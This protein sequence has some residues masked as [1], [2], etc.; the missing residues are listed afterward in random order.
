M[1]SISA[2]GTYIVVELILWI[3]TN[4]LIIIIPCKNKVGVAWALFHPN[5]VTI[6]SDRSTISFLKFHNINRLWWNY[7]FRWFTSNWVLFSSIQYLIYN[8]R[9]FKKRTSY[10]KSNIE[11]NILTVSLISGNIFLL[12]PY[13]WCSYTRTRSSWH[14]KCAFSCLSI[15]EG[16]FISDSTDGWKS[17]FIH[18]HYRYK[19]IGTPIII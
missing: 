1:C 6:F 9:S 19:M 8:K 2:F 4:N 13:F 16:I 15:M 5:T 18:S 3:W 14:N 17:Y 11:K 10:S 7:H 12:Y